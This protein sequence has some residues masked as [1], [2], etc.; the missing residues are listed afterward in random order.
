MWHTEKLPNEN[1]HYLV[2]YHEWIDK[3]YENETGISFDE[4]KVKILRFHNNEW[5][6]PVSLN[7]TISKYKQQEVIAWDVLPKPYKAKTNE[8]CDIQQM[9]TLST[10]HLPEDVL[11]N[12]FK[13]VAQYGIDAYKKSDDDGDYGLFIYI[14]DNNTPQDT[15]QDTP[16]ALKAVME[17]AI[18]KNCSVICFDSDGQIIH[19]LPTYKYE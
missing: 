17:Y 11:N 18:N 2:T 10:T 15:P 4:T 9:I 5:K 8:L 1:G 3:K 7:E 16:Q 14:T 6:M 13:D 12:L 19:D